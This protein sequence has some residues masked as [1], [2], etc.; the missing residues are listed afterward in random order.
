MTGQERVDHA[1]ERWGA[2]MG[3]RDKP[4]GEPVEKLTSIQV[5]PPNPLMLI[6]S[7]IDKGIDPDRLGKLLDLQERYE[8]S[9][10]VEAFHAAMNACQSEMPLVVRDAENTQTRS[11]YA[12]LES[13]Q[14]IAKPVYSRHG[15]ALSF[16]EADCAKEGWKRIVCDVRHTGGHSATYHIDLPIDGIG[17]KGNAIGGMNPVQG[18]VSTLSYGQRTL[19]CRIFNVTVADED[20]DGQCEG[21]ITVEQRDQLESLIKQKNVDRDRFLHWANIPELVDMPRADFPKALD[22]LRRK[23]ANA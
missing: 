1:F 4:Q 8:K 22:M 18:C 23:K 11:R 20:I 14:A 3:W 6:A 10:A 2:E 19:T 16:G 17:A 5:D 21:F 13:I 9:R 12:T 7:A 15:F